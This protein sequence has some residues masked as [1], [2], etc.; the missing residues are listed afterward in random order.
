SGWEETK[1]GAAVG[2][3]SPDDRTWLGCALIYY[4][5][6]PLLKKGGFRAGKPG[7]TDLPTVERHG[8]P[9]HVSKA[10]N[11]I[12]SIATD[13]QDPRGMVKARLLEDQSWPEYP[14]S[15]HTS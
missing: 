8:G 9:E 10:G 7:S 6:H 1:E 2:W 15:R 4:P 3:L 5:L 13:P 14:V 12:V 11:R